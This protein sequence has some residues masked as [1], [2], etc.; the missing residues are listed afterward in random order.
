MVFMKNK[1][2]TMILIEKKKR[3]KEMMDIM[4]PISQSH[5]L[6]IVIVG[7]HNIVITSI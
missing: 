3:G 2:E 6:N 1:N 5:F 4:W 7:D